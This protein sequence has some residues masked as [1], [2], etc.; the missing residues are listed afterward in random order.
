MTRTRQ[1]LLAEAASN[2]TT[3]TTIANLARTYKDMARCD[4][5]C[6]TCGR[7]L[8]PAELPA[9]LARQVHSR[10]TTPPPPLLHS[11]LPPP[12][13]MQ[14]WLWHTYTRVMHS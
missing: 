9:F 12:P 10:H 4:G 11:L 13:R 8:S 14:M 6:H 7:A 3:A 5:A 2:S 1:A